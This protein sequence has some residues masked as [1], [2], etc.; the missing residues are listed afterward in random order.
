MTI[1]NAGGDVEEW[2]LSCGG[3]VN[4]AAT[5]ENSLV[6]IK[7]N[8][9]FSY[10]LKLHSWEFIP[11]KWTQNPVH[12]HGGVTGNRQKLKTTKTSFNG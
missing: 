4:G 3:S 2:D 8:M 9:Y 11:E 1:S 5:L 7:L 6:V 10:D 12:A